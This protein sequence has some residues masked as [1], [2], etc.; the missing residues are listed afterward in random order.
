MPAEPKIPILTI[1]DQ[2]VILDADLARLYDV[3][4]KALNQAVKRN[5]ERFPDDLL[6]QLTAAEKTE[7]VTNCDH[8]RGLRFAKSLPYAFTEY[9]ALMAANVLNSAEAVKMSLYIIRAFV[10]MRERLTANAAILQRLAEIDRMLL[11]HDH[12]LRD[13]LQKL[14]PLLAPLP[15]PP[16]RRIGFQPGNK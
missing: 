11:V 6:F 7:V 4:T 8:L 2:R 12:A 5:S 9:G 3:K 10:R 13:V 16:K 15:D 14:R 1:R